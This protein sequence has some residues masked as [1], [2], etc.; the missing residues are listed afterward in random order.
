[1]LDIN[2]IF[3]FT[4]SSFLLALAPGPDN[5]YILT[6]SI[7]NRFKTAFITILGLCTGIII[8][9]LGA[10]F[11]I[12]IIFQTSEL[13]F[14]IVKYLGA[15]YLIYLAYQAFK[16]KDE[17]LD[18][19]GKNSSIQLK[20]LYIKGFFM[21]LLNPKVALFFLALLPQFVNPNLGN[22]SFQM[23]I[24]GIIFIISTIITFSM[25]A[26]M[27][28]RLSLKLR[29]NPAIVSKLNLLTA[30]VLLGLG[31]RLLFTGR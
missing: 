26:Y 7:T 24:L 11:G 10:T 8:H 9:T 30:F 16:H 27:G 25:I 20:R 18:L 13:A 4:I 1:M 14:D 6:L 28:N 15:L 12:S 22:I 21:N 19:D 23:I 31:L 3:L 2:L 17:K 5:I 29:Q